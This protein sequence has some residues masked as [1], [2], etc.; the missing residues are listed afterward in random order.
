MCDCPKHLLKGWAGWTVPAQSSARYAPDGDWVDLSHP[1]D[2]KTPRVPF[3]PPPEIK[4]VRSLP[5]H[6]INVT[7]MSMIVHTGTHIDAPIHLFEDAPPMQD[8]PLERL[9]G[10]GYILPIDTQGGYFIEPSHL[11]SAGDKI[12]AGDILLLNTGTHKL[13]HTDAYEDHPSL[14]VAAAQWLVERGIK[15]LGVDFPTPDNAVQRRDDSFDYPVHR[16]LLGNGVLIAEHVTN[17]DALSGQ[18]VEVM[19]AALNITHSDGAPVRL[20]ARP[21][22]EH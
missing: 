2:E 15:L 20:L 3:F 19:C 17:L 4:R 16:Q 1:L 6:L 10:T 14:S 9:S 13:V 22:A 18:R 8:V 5:Q 12:Q 7:Q 21:I 11:E